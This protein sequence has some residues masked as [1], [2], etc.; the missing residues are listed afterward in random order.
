MDN[1]AINFKKSSFSS[2]KDQSEPVIESG[3]WYQLANKHILFCGDTTRSSFYERASGAKLTLAIVSRRQR[4]HWL[5]KVSNTLVLIK[6]TSLET[7]LIE[8]TLLLYSQPGDQVMF[9]WLPASGMLAIAHRLG[10][11]IIAGDPSAENCSRAIMEA[12][13]GADMLVS[14]ESP[15]YL[16]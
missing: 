7:G 6:G 13:F 10:R 2:S 4:H 1:I 16:S 11:R 12:N 5:A 3:I 15:K 8:Q 9:P 14:G